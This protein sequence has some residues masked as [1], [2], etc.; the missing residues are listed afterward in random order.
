MESNW[1]QSVQ[2][3]LKVMTN[4]SSRVGILTISV[5]QTNQLTMQKTISCIAKYCKE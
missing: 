4:I 3:K 1:L 2:V 5:T